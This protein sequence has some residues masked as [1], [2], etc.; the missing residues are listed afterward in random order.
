MD[1]KVVLVTGATSGIG[2]AAAREL[3]GRRHTVVLSG[4]DR[5]RIVAL[6]RELSAKGLRVVAIPGDLALETDAREVVAES[7]KTFGEVHA[8]VHAAGVFQVSR[9]E[10]TSSDVFRAVLDANL[11]AL[12]HLLRHLLPHFYARGRGHVVAIGSV[13]SR[14]A[15]PLETAYCAAKWGL[16]G[17]L[18]ALRLEG[19]ERGLKVTLVN[20]GPTATPIWSAYPGKAPLDRMLRP[21]DV[22]QVAAFALDLPENVLLEEV[23]VTPSRDPFRGEGG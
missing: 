5:A 23:T 22:A 20:P 10:D 12:H 2:E 6:E 11:T 18:E 9:L 1:R 4:R 19:R 8:L 21:E 16:S 15:F 17:F 13:A 3:A 14:R 7:L